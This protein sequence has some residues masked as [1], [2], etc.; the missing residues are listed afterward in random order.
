MVV[1]QKISLERNEHE[2]P[3]FLL[4]LGCHSKQAGDEGD[5]TSDV[6][7]GHALH[8]PLADHVHALVP[9]ERP[10]CGLE[11][12][13]THPWFDQPFDQAVVLLHQIIQVFD[14]ALVRP[15]REAGRWL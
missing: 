8:L 3:S 10:V 7:F 12:K 6:A 11:R 13:E 2:D 15:P 4:S 9:L 1:L 14:Q 5:L